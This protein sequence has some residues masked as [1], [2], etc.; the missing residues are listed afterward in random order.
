MKS[1]SESHSV[2]SDSLRP[3]GLYSPWNSPGQNTRVGSLSLLQGVFPTQGLNQESLFLTHDWNRGLPHCRQILYQLSYQVGK[4]QSGRGRASRMVMWN[5]QGLGSGRAKHQPLS[6]QG[7]GQSWVKSPRGVSPF[8]PP[9]FS[10]SRDFSLYFIERWG[11]KPWNKN[12]H[13]PPYLTL[14]TNVLTEIISRLNV[15]VKTVRLLEEDIGVNLRNLGLGNDHKM[16]TE[17]QAT[18]E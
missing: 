13:K 16:I 15:K 3:H 4:W 18:K 7:Q 10:L 14:N 9:E 2:V 12:Y 1:E 6:S 5:G 11:P 8:F 17:A